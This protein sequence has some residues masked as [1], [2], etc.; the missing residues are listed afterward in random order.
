MLQPGSE[1]AGPVVSAGE[2][3]AE[4]AADPPTPVTPASEAP[5]AECDSP[6]IEVRGVSFS[7]GEEPFIEGLSASFPHGAVTSVVG[8]NGCGKSTLVKLV[9]GLLRPRVGEV[10]VDGVP[11]LSMKA[12]ERARRVAV[13]AQASRP[14]AMTVEALV[15]C[16]R[17]PYQSHQGRL[18]REDREHVEHALELAGIAR[19][20]DHEL[21][22]LSG[23]ERQRAFI[24][25]T[26]AQDTDLIVL[27]EPTTYLDIRACHE[28]M[29]LVRT[30]NRDHGK[31]IVM[32]IHDLDLALRYSDRLLVM[33]R[34]RATCAG[35]VDEVLA[36][37]AIEHAFG[38]TIQPHET[39]EGRAY[40]LFPAQG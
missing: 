21:R 22:R 35:A 20:R 23:G 27:D 15:A 6:A 30:L 19:F 1:V 3:R 14:P 38:V 8:P 10:F 29:E 18:S 36:A 4:L 28:T 26:L 5:V 37:H 34:G 12:K 33:E 9:D 25:M 16:G 31:T 17:Y 2:A 40:T 11:T 7:Y 39:K 24:A 32:V 13:L